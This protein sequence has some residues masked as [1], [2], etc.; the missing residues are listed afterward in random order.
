[1]EVCTGLVC[2]ISTLKQNIQ[3]RETMS[4]GELGTLKKQM[5]AEIHRLQQEM[6]D[7]ATD[8]AA[9]I[10]RMDAAHQEAMRKMEASKAQEGEV[11]IYTAQEGEVSIIPHRRG[12]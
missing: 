8:Y 6:M 4:E 7:A 3:E 2:Q 5:E 1:M 11:S 12:R 10:H 9:K